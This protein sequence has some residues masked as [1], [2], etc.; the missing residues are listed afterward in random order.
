MSWRNSICQQSGVERVSDLNRYVSRVPIST[1]SPIDQF[2]QETR[3]IISFATPQNI[4]SSPTLGALSAVGIV[5]CC[6]NYFRQIFSEILSICS[7]AQ[8]N[9]ALQTINMGSVIWHPNS[10]MAKGA[11]EHTS[12]AASENICKTSDKY[13]GIK[14][15]SLGLEAILTEFDKICELR[16]GIVHSNR[17]LAGKNGIKLK[18]ESSSDLTLID[19][20]FAELQEILAVCQALIIST[21]SK[22]FGVMCERWAKSWRANPSWNVSKE[23]EKFKQIWFLFRSNMDSSNSLIARDISW[24]K[25]RNEVKKEFNV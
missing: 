12:L 18:L 15:K 25:C 23:N 3:N 1:E 2:Y 20:K 19:V 9:A 6:E 10:E 17:V 16:H 13:L 14:L 24:I 8:K 4:S 7:D 11:F 5:S 22:L 21:N